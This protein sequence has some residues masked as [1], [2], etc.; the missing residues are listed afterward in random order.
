M[1]KE[2]KE[3]LLAAEK[4]NDELVAKYEKRGEI[5]YVPVISVVIAS[6]YLFISISIPDNVS[7]VELH[8]Y[9]S[10][11]NDRIYYVK[12]NTYETFYKLIKRKFLEIKNDIYDV[13]L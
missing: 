5:E 2:H 10:E 6:S 1:R 12:S 8:L 13:K 7:G 3:A 4:I 9:N 11:N